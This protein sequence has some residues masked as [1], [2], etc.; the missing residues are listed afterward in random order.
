MGFLRTI[1]GYPD[2][3]RKWPPV[4][5]LPLR[6]DLGQNALN[7]VGLHSPWTKLSVFGPPE[8]KRRR[9]GDSLVYL[10]GGFSV[11]LQDGKVASFS[12]VW[13]D[14]LRHGFQPFQGDFIFAGQP[15]ALDEKTE[16]AALPSIFGEPFWRDENDDEIV[17]FYEKNG[18]EWQ[19][20]AD[21][22]GRLKTLL[23]LAHPVL[24]EESQRE[25]YKITKPWPHDA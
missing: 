2:P 17:V 8:M 20:E 4:S 6:F 25:A 23:V 22:K 11:D 18:V 10:S 1:L 13:V 15:I 21:P 3:A 5:S 7:G 9:E 16:E 12:F 24:A 14:Y 19:F